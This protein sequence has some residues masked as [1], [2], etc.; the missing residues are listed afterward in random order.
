MGR[1]EKT[2]MSAVR[3]SLGE[4][5]TSEEVEIALNLMRQG[6]GKLRSLDLEGSVRYGE[7]G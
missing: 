4:Q 5:N 2:A 3:F 1:D 7:M 6:I